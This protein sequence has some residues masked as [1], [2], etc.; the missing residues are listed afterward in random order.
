M[1]RLG[2]VLAF[3]MMLVI[4][5]AVTIP[6]SVINRWVLPQATLLNVSGNAFS[7][8]WQG[9]KI[10]DKTYPMTCQYQRKSGLNYQLNCQTPLT[11]HATV[12]INGLQSLT[13]SDTTLSGEIAQLQ[14][15]LTLSGLPAS[16][17]TALNGEIGL[18]IEKAEMS[19]QQLTYLQASGNAKD[20]TW[21]GQTLVAALQLRTASPEKPIRLTF[22]TPPETNTAS[23]TAVYLETELQGNRYRTIGEL[24]GQSV[25]QYPTLFR[26]IGQ[27]AASNRVSIDWQGTLEF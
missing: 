18:H 9:I 20:F 21:S 16:L 23:A 6:L 15:W 7:G 19:N 4:C 11:L 24:K 25:S 14:T 3:S 27:P 2:Y 5:L 12:Q 10:A 17:S 8:R 22:S 26:F 13:L 1:R